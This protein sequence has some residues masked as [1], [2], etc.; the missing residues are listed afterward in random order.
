MEFTIPVSP[1]ILKAVS[2]LDRLRGSWSATQAISS[3]RLS[4]IE[5]A[6]RVQSVGAS[7]RLAGIRLSDVEVAALLEGRGLTLRDS[8]QIRGYASAMTRPFPGE[9]EMLTCET[10]RRLHAVLVG[11]NAD[12]ISPWRESASHREAFDDE[13]RATGRIFSTLPP[14]WISGKLEDLMTWFE[15]EL[16]SGEHHPVLVIATLILG[17]LAASPF[18]FGNGRLSRVLIGH[19]MRRA[20]YGYMPYASVE[21]QMEELRDTYFEAFGH[22]QTRLWTGDARLE[23]WLEFFLQVLARH[24]QRVETKVRL[25]QASL[26]FPPLQQSI[27]EAVR[28]HGTVDAAL[29][30]KATGANRNTL[31]DNLRRLVERGVLEKSGQRRG[32]RY[33]ISLGVERA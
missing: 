10:L 17:L 14:R 28:E 31:K 12:S 32:T 1:R 3:D 18:D 21:A 22:S 13:G 2:R 30:L 15:L 9:G 7:C 4:R 27:I 8:D 19:L 25:E 23:P 33:R 24:Q 6:A 5:E 16:R 29:L 11:A 20:G 26:A